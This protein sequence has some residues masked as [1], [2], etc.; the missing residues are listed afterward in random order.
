[1]PI[2]NHTR[3]DEGNYGPTTSGNSYLSKADHRMNAAGNAHKTKWSIQEG[4]EYEVFRLSDEIDNN[5]NGDF[6]W[7]CPVNNCL[8]S[9]INGCKVVIGGNGERIAKFV[10]PPNAGEC[11][12]GYPVN[13]AKQNDKPSEELL[14]KLEEISIISKATKRK[15]ERGRI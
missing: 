1:M 9:M 14:D 6:R 8:F 2:E 5:L 10:E 7:L 13:T 15:I 3:N 12:H 11:W 4:Q